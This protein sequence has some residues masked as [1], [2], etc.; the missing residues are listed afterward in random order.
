MEPSWRIPKP[1]FLAAAMLTSM[2][3]AC[4]GRP[5]E[6]I[7]S[8]VGSAPSSITV[9]GNS[10]GQS[11]QGP[12]SAVIRDTAVSGSRAERNSDRQPATSSDAADDDA[13]PAEQPLT[14]EDAVTPEMNH[15][16]PAPDAQLA[17]QPASAS[18]LQLESHVDAETTA[19]PTPL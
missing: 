15:S 14:L 4:G 16:D 8:D 7:G 1:A 6:G 18:G 12:L 9:S 11:V 17:S 3:I 19:E 13:N 10:E 2:L 5:N